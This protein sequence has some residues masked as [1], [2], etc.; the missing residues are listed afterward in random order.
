MRFIFWKN[1]STNDKD[2]AWQLC[3]LLFVEQ[4]AAHNSSKEQTAS[5]CG[6]CACLA[7]DNLVVWCSQAQAIH[8]DCAI[9]SQHLRAREIC[10]LTRRSEAQNQS[11]QSDQSGGF[12]CGDDAAAAAAQ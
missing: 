5:A 7:V 8:P 12:M 6:A 2:E 3:L 10:S 11:D 4:K 9:I 1:T